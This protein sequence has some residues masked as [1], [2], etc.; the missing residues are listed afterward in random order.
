MSAP[1]R[2]RGLIGRARIALLAAGA[3]FYLRV[4]AATARIVWVGSTLEAMR[5]RGAFPCVGVFWHS[6]L[7]W[8]A[9]AFRGGD[10]AVMVSDHRD[11]ELIGRIVGSWGTRTL[12]GSS[13]RGGIEAL[14][15]AQRLL[16]SGISVGV[17]PDGPLGPSEVAKEGAVALASLSARPIVPFSYAASAALTLSTWDR[18]RLPMPWSRV[19]VAFGE[20]IAV[21]AGLD[22]AGIEAHRR[23]LDAELVRLGAVTEAALRPRAA[24]VIG[25]A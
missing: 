19:A 8:A 6:R 17:A 24:V 25:N 11:G 4:L 10:Y 22:A 15:A 14:R 12:E 1:V 18:L 9:I 23:A 16:A 20:P 3:R 5:E 2:R 7:V 21:P 13:R